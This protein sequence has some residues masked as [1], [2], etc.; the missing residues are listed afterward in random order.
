MIWAAVIGVV[1]VVHLATVISHR[2]TVNSLVDTFAVEQKA[3]AEERKRLVAAI[4]A[5]NPGEFAVYT[6]EPRPK[7]EKPYV[8]PDENVPVGL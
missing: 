5:R 8:E 7:K 2:L 1:V 4:L 3:A 6:R